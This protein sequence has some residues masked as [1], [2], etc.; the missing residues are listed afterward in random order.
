MSQTDGSDGTRWEGYSDY[1]RVSINIAEAVDRA[2][3]S[4]A[5]INGLHAEGAKVRAE[6]AAEARANILS[7][8]LRLVPE[9]ANDRDD[10]REYDRMLSDWSARR[11]Q[12]RVHR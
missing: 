7:A 10:V 6:T 11:R 5:R 8:G 12:Q 3:D 1:E 9:L 4:Y 2:M